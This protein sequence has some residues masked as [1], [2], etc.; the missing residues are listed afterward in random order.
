MKNLFFYLKLSVLASSFF[1]TA[2][3]GSSKAQLTAKAPELIVKQF[4]AGGTPFEM[5]FRAGVAHN[6]PTFSVWIENMQGE[7]IQTLF[8]TKS[9]ATGYYNYGDAGDGKWLKVPGRSIRP[10]A[11]PY[12]LHKRERNEDESL[13]P[14]PE[15]PV[16]DAYTGATP[17][18]SFMLKANTKAS[19]PE[20]F[21][22]LLEVNQ[23]WDWNS[24]WTNA[25]YADNADYK[26]SAQ[27][28]VVY[29]VDIDLKSP[30]PQYF[31]NPIG[32]G[33]YAGEDGRL[34]TDLSGHTTALQ[35]FQQISLTLK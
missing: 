22:V 27:P 28:S 10:A 8:V 14:T 32:H 16:L 15:N 2:C 24:F 34:Y 20:R 6:Y 29:A 30:M 18:G 11:L 5:Q 7:M 19:L 13:M 3:K 9:L 26:S 1:L 12:W 35:I 21:R 25:K 17:S 33:H 23:P 31:L 4:S